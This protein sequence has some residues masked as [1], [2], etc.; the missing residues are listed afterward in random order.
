MRPYIEQ[1][2]QK[3]NNFFEMK[4]SQRWMLLIT[5][6]YRGGSPIYM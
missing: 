1:F 5:P 6:H 3:T 2:Q 4:L